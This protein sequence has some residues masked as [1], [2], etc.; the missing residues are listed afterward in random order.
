MGLCLS[1][2]DET[3]HNTAQHSTAQHSTAAQHRV[4]VFVSFVCRLVQSNF[5]KEEE[6]GASFQDTMFK[7]VRTLPQLFEYFPEC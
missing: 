4:C 6:W 5:V 2:G 7:I 3:Q 1:G